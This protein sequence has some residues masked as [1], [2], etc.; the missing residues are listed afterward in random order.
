MSEVI[1][2]YESTLYLL[3]LLVLLNSFCHIV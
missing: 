1:L 3:K 2:P